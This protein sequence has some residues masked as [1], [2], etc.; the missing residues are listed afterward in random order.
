MGLIFLLEKHNILTNVQHG[1]RVGKLT[2]AA[3]KSF[4]GS[5]LEVMD[6]HLNAVGIFLHLAEACDVLNHQIL[7]KKL[8][9]YRVG[10]V[11]KS[12]LKSYLSNLSQFGDITKIGYNTTVHRYSS[13]S[14]ETA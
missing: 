12:L 11:L 9:I 1:F 13:L 6:K 3:C 2:A 8:E 4:I 14:R 5:S 10:G 7:L